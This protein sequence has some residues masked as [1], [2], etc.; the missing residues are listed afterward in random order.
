MRHRL[1]QILSSD[2]RDD[3]VSDGNGHGH[4]HAIIRR[5]YGQAS[6]ETDETPPSQASGGRVI[7][8]RQWARSRRRRFV[9]AAP[10]R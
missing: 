10:A 2:E 1:M 5:F 4:G 7:D 9:G 6:P 8:L 3:V